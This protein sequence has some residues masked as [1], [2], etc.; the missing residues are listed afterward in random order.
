MGDAIIF[1][2]GIGVGSLVTMFI[3]LVAIISDDIRR[4]S[5]K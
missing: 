5:E 1:M 4:E 2:A 3:C